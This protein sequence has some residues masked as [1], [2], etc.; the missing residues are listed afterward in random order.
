MKLT[1]FDQ[2]I[3]VYVHEYCRALSDA[4][5]IVTTIMYV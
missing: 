5:K 2:L 1:Y 4:I 3:E